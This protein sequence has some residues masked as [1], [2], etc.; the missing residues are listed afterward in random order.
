[1]SVPGYEGTTFILRVAENLKNKPKGPQPKP[2][3]KP[4]PTQ[5]AK[6]LNSSSSSHHH[7]HPPKEK[8]KEKRCGEAKGWFDPFARENVEED[9]FVSHLSETHSL[10]LNKFNVVENHLLLITS[11]F[12]S[13]DDPV[14]ARDFQHVFQVFEAF[15]REIT[16]LAF[17]NC[18]PKSGMSQ[19]HKHIQILPMPLAPSLAPSPSPS[20]PQPQQQQQQQQQQLFHFPLDVLVQKS[21]QQKMKEKENQKELQL[22]LQLQLQLQQSQ[23]Q[24]FCEVEGLPYVAYLAPV[25]EEMKRMATTT[26]ARERER[27]DHQM[28]MQM[29]RL[30]L[31]EDQVEVAREKM[32]K[33]HGMKEEDW[34]YNLLL[35][36]HWWMLVPR[37]KE[38]FGPIGIN[39]MGYAG[40]F[41]LRSK[42]ELEFLEKYNAM[43][44][45][46]HAGYPTQHKTQK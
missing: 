10:L 33:E 8:E 6:D 39:A 7:H 9:L 36:P 28:Q 15:P 41:L 31:L 42:E 1:M 40:T 25:E 21:L 32:V 18:G 12:E 43:D 35:S 23:Q 14:N 44:I 17:Y 2:T 19:P 29:Q 24:L 46:T 5:N 45:L 4:T 27:D 20:P 3:P 26:M 30:K 34:S 13:Q 11:S 38:A 16:P 22:E 37:R